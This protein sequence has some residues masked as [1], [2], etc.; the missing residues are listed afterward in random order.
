MSN[1]EF[2]KTSFETVQQSADRS[3]KSE[4]VSFLMKKGVFSDKRQASAVTFVV[5]GLIFIIV[6]F[7]LFRSTFGGNNI[8]TKKNF[9]PA[10]LIHHLNL[11]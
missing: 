10:T 4:M 3:D 2:E 8:D 9:R 5:V 1:V 6:L 7:F 11:M